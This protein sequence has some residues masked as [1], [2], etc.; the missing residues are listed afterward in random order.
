[1]SCPVVFEDLGD[2]SC[3]EIIYV[4]LGIVGDLTTQDC[5]LE[6]SREHELIICCYEAYCRAVSA[7]QSEG[8]QHCMHS[9]GHE[10]RRG[11]DVALD[12]QYWWHGVRV[13]TA[14]LAFET[15]D[16]LQVW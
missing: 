1:M 6:R 8:G 11:A 9:L 7:S 4:S 10:C 13:T 3:G 15:V 5:S 14:R 12:L 2:Q 16:S